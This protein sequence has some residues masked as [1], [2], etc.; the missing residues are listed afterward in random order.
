MRMKTVQMSL[1]DTYNDVNSTME[2]NKP[3]FLKLLEEHIDFSEYIPCKRLSSVSRYSA[4][5]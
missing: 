3:K 5:Y 4:W 1:T 2:N